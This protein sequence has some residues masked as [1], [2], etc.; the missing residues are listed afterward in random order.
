MQRVVRQVCVI[1]II[2]IHS[3]QPIENLTEIF[4]SYHFTHLF[5][6]NS[7][8]LCGVATYSPSSRTLVGDIPALLSLLVSVEEMENISINHLIGV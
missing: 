1:F 8:G 7:P 4:I 6:P 5:L 2:A 3:R